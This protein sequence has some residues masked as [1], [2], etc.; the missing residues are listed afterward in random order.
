MLLGGCCL[1]S[2]NHYSTFKYFVLKLILVLKF[3]SYLTFFFPKECWINVRI[4]QLK[5]IPSAL[6]KTLIIRCIMPTPMLIYSFYRRNGTPAH[7]YNWNTPNRYILE[8]LKLKFTEIDKNAGIVLRKSRDGK[9]FTQP[10][11]RFFCEK[12]RQILCI[13]IFGHVTKILL[14]NF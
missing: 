4:N 10:F 6:I 1:C 2:R 7:I 11:A 3:L 13:W 14:A 9:K 8:L 12:Y 5:L